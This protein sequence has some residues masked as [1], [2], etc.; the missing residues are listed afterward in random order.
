MERVAGCAVMLGLAGQ[1]EAAS[2]PSI[3]VVATAKP[4][5]G[6]TGAR[7]PRST[8][9]HLRRGRHRRDLDDPAAVEPVDTFAIRLDQTAGR[10]RVGIS[11]G[12]ALATRTTGGSA[13]VF[14]IESAKCAR[15]ETGCGPG[16]ATRWPTDGHLLFPLSRT[17]RGIMR[18]SR[19]ELTCATCKRLDAITP[20][21][22]T[23]IRPSTYCALL[24]QALSPKP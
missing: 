9:A 2:R 24:S 22:Q 21:Q 18:A 14:F 20:A 6:H 7:K 10:R 15:A 12:T 8:R 19:T 11:D 4:G 3:S 17:P 13:F 5:R 16:L 1:A 23:A